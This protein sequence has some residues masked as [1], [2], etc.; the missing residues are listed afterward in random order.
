GLR[1]RRVPNG[2]AVGVV[3]LGV[4]AVVVGVSAFVGSSLTAFVEALPGYQAR[5]DART[6]GVLDW[7]QRRGVP[8]PDRES[9]LDTIEPG[10][11]FGLVATLLNQVRAL[12]TNGVLVLLTVVFILLEVGSF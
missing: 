11:A 1:R 2:L 3:V 9:F 12:L 8:M 4:V 7:F 5:L 10:Y 6:V